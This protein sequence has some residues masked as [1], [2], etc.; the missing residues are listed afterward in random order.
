MRYA[1]VIT[2]LFFLTA[3]ASAQ[4]NNQ[5][6]PLKPAMV[7]YHFIQ[8]NGD[9]ANGT[10]WFSAPGISGAT[11]AGTGASWTSVGNMFAA[12]DT[13]VPST[14]IYPEACCGYLTVGATTYAWDQYDYSGFA[15]TTNMH[16]IVGEPFTFPLTA[17]TTP[18]AWTVQVPAKLYADD[19]YNPGLPSVTLAWQEKQTETTWR[20][21]VTHGTLTLHCDYYPSDQNFPVGSY[22][23]VEGYFST[24]SQ[25][26]KHQTQ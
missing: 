25:I 7:A 2:T 14:E 26:G 22:Q 3:I 16:R 20:F 12:G 17:S 18:A 23:V 11:T 1:F 24:E 4:N 19:E 5:N 8:N 15:I 10:L 21:L 6:K 13:L 9:G